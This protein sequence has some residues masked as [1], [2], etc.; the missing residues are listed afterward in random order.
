MRQ[1]MLEKIH[2][3]H[4]G[5]EACKR[6]A[7]DVLFWPGMAAQIL[8][9][10]DQCDACNAYMAKQQKE[11]MISYE[12]PTRPWK[13]VSQD[14]FSYLITVDHY[15]DYWE[16]DNVTGDISAE[17]IS[18]LHE[19]TLLTAWNT[20]QSHNGQ[21]WTVCGSMVCRVCEELGV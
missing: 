10:V 19:T 18:Q 11:T 2:A 5:A 12:I 7:K 4:L 16:L 13:I 21:W 14:L 1:Q 6:M 20:R 9:R 15:S 8:D 17:V 3:S